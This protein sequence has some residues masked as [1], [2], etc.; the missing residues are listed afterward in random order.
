[1]LTTIPPPAQDGGISA[2]RLALYV[3]LGIACLVF[4]GI[5]LGWR[6]VL[7][8]GLRRRVAAVVAPEPP[9]DPTTLDPAPPSADREIYQPTP[10]VIEASPAEPPAAPPAAPPPAPAAP[11]PASAAAGPDASFVDASAPV[12]LDGAPEYIPPTTEES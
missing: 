6:A 3:G 4:L 9:F 7:F 1:V 12:G 11:P 2:Y 5:L 8:A 10:R